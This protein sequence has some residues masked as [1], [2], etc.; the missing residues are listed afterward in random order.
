M[1]LLA[2]IISLLGCQSSTYDVTYKNV[3]DKW[4]FD[5]KGLWASYGLP[6]GSVSG[7]SGGGTNGSLDYP[8]PKKAGARWTNAS[9]KKI[10]NLVDIDRKLFPKINNNEFY[11][12][13]FELR[14]DDIRQLE[15]VVHDR[16]YSRSKRRKVM[17]YCAEPDGCQF[18]S[19]FTTDS[20]Y[21][22]EQQAEID[23]RRKSTDAKYFQI[24]TVSEYFSTIGSGFAV[25]VGSELEF[26]YYIYLDTR[27]N[28]AR[29]NYIE[30]EFQNPDGSNPFFVSGNVSM[31]RR[32]ELVT[33]PNNYNFRSPQVKGIKQHT[34][35]SI[36]IRLYENSSK[37]LLL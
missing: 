6:I 34:N 30:I 24:K 18:N 20:Y 3:S 9:G 7:K 36:V 35:Y 26:K 29:S 17:L 21:S 37:K 10:R 5:S 11:E 14:Q 33:H 19:P 28:L 1:L 27:K 2:A 31:L 13:I 12:F 4:I 23:R 25:N 32:F 16:N 15:L 22:P 8:I